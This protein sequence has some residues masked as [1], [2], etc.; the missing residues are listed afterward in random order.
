MVVTPPMFTVRRGVQS[1]LRKQ[2]RRAI[3][4]A[5]TV[6]QAACS[7]ACCSAYRHITF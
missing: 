4:H 5:A 6:E 7:G 2:G 3:I 1:V